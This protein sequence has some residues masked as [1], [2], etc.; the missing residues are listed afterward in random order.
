MAKFE[1]A[2]DKVYKLEFNEPANALHKN[3][4]EDDV[5]FMGV[6]RTAHPKWEGWKLVDKYL[7]M[8]DNPRAASV[9][10]YE[11]EQLRELVNQFYKTYFWDKMGLDK[12][13][14]Q[15]IAEEMFVFGVN[16]GTRVAVKTAQRVVGAKEDGMV[17][18]ATVAALD[19]YNEDKFD[20]RYDAEEVAYYQELVNKNI[21]FSV[22]LK[23]WKNRAEAV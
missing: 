16:A 4:T 15:H 2:I 1:E 21:K 12:V 19:N 5:T 23:G 8:F 10:A 6:Y 7:T 3:K 17:G 9:A 14:S 22:Y 11:D 20:I 13:A 18:P